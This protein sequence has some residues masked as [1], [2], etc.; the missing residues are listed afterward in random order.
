[1]VLSDTPSPNSDSVKSLRHWLAF[2]DWYQ[3]PH[4]VHFDSWD[5]LMAKLVTTDLAAVNRAMKAYNEQTR[6]RLVQTWRD[7]FRNVT[8]ARKQRIPRDYVTAL[9]SQGLSVP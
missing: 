3:W 6:A 2:C 4:V 1:M 9:R 7:I 5:D 8:A